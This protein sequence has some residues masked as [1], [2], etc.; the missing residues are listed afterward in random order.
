MKQENYR[1]DFD[2]LKQSN[3]MKYLDIHKTINQREKFPRKKFQPKLKQKIQ[4]KY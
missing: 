2:L 4:M 1:K 3:N